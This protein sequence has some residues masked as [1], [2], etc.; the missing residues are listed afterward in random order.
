MVDIDFKAWSTK[1]SNTY[2]LN[3]TKPIMTKFLQWIA[4]KMA[5]SGHIE[6]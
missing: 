2:N 5:D 6:S 4:T 3:T 1:K